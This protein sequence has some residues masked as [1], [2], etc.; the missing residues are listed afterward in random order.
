MKT[1]RK[2]RMPGKKGNWQELTIN[3]LL[4]VLFLCY[5]VYIIK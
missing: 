2:Y 4:V 1:G 3:S 5:M